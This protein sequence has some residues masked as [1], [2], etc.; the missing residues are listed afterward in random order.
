[1]NGLSALQFTML[2][3]VSFSF[4]SVLLWSEYVTS[5]VNTDP[6]SE[7]SVYK[8]VTHVF[9]IVHHYDSSRSQ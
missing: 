4:V 8:H 3:T 5:V 2:Q 6:F 7:L 9:L 1:M